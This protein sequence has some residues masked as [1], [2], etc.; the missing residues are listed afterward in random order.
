[1]VLTAQRQSILKKIAA[2]DLGGS[3]KCFIDCL[4]VEAGLAENTI[5]AYCRD[6]RGFLE[7]CSNSKIRRTEQIKPELVNDY[8]RSLSVDSKSEG[9]VKRSLVAI[10]MFL[11]YCKGTGRI[12]DDFASVLDGPKLW[13][14]L[15]CVCSERQVLDLLRAPDI[16][17]PFYFRDKAMLELL[18]ATGVRAGEVANMKISNI[19]LDIGYLR[20][21]GKGNKERVIPLSKVA[22]E[23]IRQY[24]ENL[25]PSLAKSF[26]EDFLLLSRTGRPLS[27]IEVWRLVKKYAVRAG[28]PRNLT[29]HTLRHCFATHL[30][31]GGA[32]LRSVQEM[33]GHVDIA[34]TQIYT[35]VDQNRLRSIHRKFH[36]RP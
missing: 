36:P 5:L 30:L 18:Y 25:R 29:V 19:K 7:F 14:R 15:P 2:V 27:R 9:T 1:M 28:M 35:H 20:C 31:S 13:Q 8:M 4:A 11:R 32:D 6:L 23:A 17:E 22:A 12:Q 34:T 3:V 10:R 33:L 26:S 24:L 16:K 21:I